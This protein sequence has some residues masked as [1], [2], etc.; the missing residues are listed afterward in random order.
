MLD[1]K[2]AVAPPAQPGRLPAL[3]A[4]GRRMLLAGLLSLG[5]LAGLLSIAIGWLIGQLSASISLGALGAVLGLV[6]C[7]FL[8]KYAERVLAEKLGQH[9]VAQLRRGLVT[10]ALRSARGPSMGITIARSTND[11]SSIRN[12][13][14]QGMVPLV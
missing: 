14:V 5:I 13:I 12:W 7:F 8:A 6:A 3:V 1:Q 4:P 9:Y 11:L 10:H 2:I